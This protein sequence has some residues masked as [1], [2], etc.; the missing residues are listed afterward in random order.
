MIAAVAPSTWNYEETLSTLRY[1]SRAKNIKNKPRINEDPK[2]ALLRQYENEINKLKEMVE[3]LAKE[4]QTTIDPAEQLDKLRLL[5]KQTLNDKNVLSVDEMMESSVGE[6]HKEELKKLEEERKILNF[7][8]DIMKNELQEREKLL[9]NEKDQKEKLEE[10]I[11]DYE[12]QL[13]VGGQALEDKEKQQARQYREMQLKLRKERKKQMKLQNE[14]QAKADE[15]LMVAKHYQGIEEELEEMKDV[16]KQ[17]RSKY[18][19]ALSEIKDLEKEHQQQKEDMLET[20]RDQQ[21][22]LDFC[23]EITEIMLSE[24]EL[25]KIKQ[26]CTFDD[27][28]QTWSIPLFQIQNKTVLLP[29]LGKQQGK[30]KLHFS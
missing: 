25:E 24:G 7:E 15:K 27:E 6:T 23:R 8:K 16:V 9:I 1:A 26:K 11:Y 22:E 29:K 12:Q 10:L 19:G 17:L 5:K 21:R 2:D 18:K 28:T 13:V 14:N 20:I 30:T 4:K 3:N